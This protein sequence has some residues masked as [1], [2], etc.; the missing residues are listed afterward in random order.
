MNMYVLVLIL[1]LYNCMM[2]DKW[3]EIVIKT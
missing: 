1:S 2:Y 3:W